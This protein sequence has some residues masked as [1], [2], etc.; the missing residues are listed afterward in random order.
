MTRIV[1]RAAVIVAAMGMGWAVARA[2]T[3]EPAFELVVDAPVGPT[4]ITCVKGCT[5]AWV[6]RGVNPDSRPT[7]TFS[8]ECSGP[9]VQRCSSHKVGG[10]IAP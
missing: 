1:L 10:W 8:F 9:N 4:T 3:A 2:Q 5:L 7:P 6:E